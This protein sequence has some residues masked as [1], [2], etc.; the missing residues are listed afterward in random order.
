MKPKRK[1]RLKKSIRKKK[2]DTWDI[3]DYAMGNDPRSP[4]WSVM[5]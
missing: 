5:P 3:L 1:T 4:A 2:K